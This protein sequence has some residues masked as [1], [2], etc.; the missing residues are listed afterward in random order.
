MAGLS[1]GTD[2]LPKLGTDVSALAERQVKTSRR[3]FLRGATTLAASQKALPACNGAIADP[4][5]ALIAEE[6]R[7]R[8]L[9]VAARARAE[10]FLF[11]LPSD[12]WPEEFDDH[13][14]MVEALSLEKRADEVYDRI[15]SKSA[16]TLAG[17]VS[18]LEWGEGDTEVTEAIIA[19]LRRWMTTRS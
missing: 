10:K 6:K 5:I 3:E 8:L 18:K 1:A 17:I 2:G 9:A 12:E 16:S 15:V 14:M 11:A 19:D 4:I 13:P 7:W